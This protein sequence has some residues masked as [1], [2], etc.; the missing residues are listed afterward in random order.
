MNLACNMIWTHNINEAPVLPGSY[1]TGTLKNKPPTMQ[2]P[3]SL[4]VLQLLPIFKGPVYPQQTFSH[5]PH[6]YRD[7]FLYFVSPQ[8]EGKNCSSITFLGVV[9]ITAQT[10]DSTNPTS[11]QDLSNSPQK[12]LC[13]SFII[14]VHMRNNIKADFP[15]NTGEKKKNPPHLKLQQLPM[16]GPPSSNPSV[17]VANYFISVT[18]MHCS[19]KAESDGC[20]TGTDSLNHF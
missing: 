10:L 18:D 17:P 5:S 19:Q 15:Q 4:K 20:A 13:A 3:E 16:E 12:P 1:F 14:T 2:P 9:F 7:I 6:A 11:V 8:C